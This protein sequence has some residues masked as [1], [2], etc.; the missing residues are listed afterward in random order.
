MGERVVPVEGGRF[1]QVRLPCETTDGWYDVRITA[2]EDP[3]FARRLMGRIENGRPG[4][5][6]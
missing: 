3:S 1:R 2:D 5:T 4:I 6:G